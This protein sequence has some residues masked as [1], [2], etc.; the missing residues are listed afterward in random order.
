[1]SVAFV[2][3]ST[4]IQEVMAR[5]GTSFRSM[6]SRKAFVHWYTR[7]GMDEMEFV[8]AE[9]S[10]YDLISEYQQ[11]Q[12]ATVEDWLEDE[13][14]HEQDEEGHQGVKLLVD[15]ASTQTDTTAPPSPEQAQD[16]TRSF[17]W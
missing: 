3:N 15:T 14:Q 4:A 5:I 16:S 2:G 10:L 8:E 9:A 12:D 1:M 17:A 11:Y 13:T 6:Y 7:E